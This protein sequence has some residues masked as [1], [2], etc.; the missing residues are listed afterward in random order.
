MS[1]TEKLKL[2][3]KSIEKK[4]AAIDAELTEISES[5][6]A[7]DAAQSITNKLYATFP[8]AGAWL[9]WSMNH[10]VEYLY[11]YGPHGMR[12]NLFAVMTGIK[13]I[14]AAMK[15]RAA[16]SP[17]QGFASQIGVTAARLII[18]ELYKTL[19][20]FGY[21]TKKSRV[22]P[23]DITKA[24]HDALH[25]ESPYE[26]VLIV[27]H[28]IQYMATYGVT[29]WYKDNYG[30]TFPIEPEIEM[31]FGASED[32]M[33]KWDWSQ[34][35]LFE[36]LYRSL[37]NQKKLGFCKG[38]EDAY[39]KIVSAYQNKELRKYLQT[40]YPILG[41][42]PTSTYGKRGFPSFEEISEFVRK[43]EEK[44]KAKEKEKK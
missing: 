11:T 27:T 24:V 37:C 8:K 31:E 9:T 32:E 36:I 20:H 5:E 30:I 41:V 40:N 14:I 33:F 25:T 16:N 7:L 29:K 17:I 12:R 4:M 19:L 18:E 15:R 35:H 44:K 2:E 42:E 23:A 22:M 43:K 28:V 39:S 6:E 21:M 38:V 10:V 3:L 26:I 1:K 13:S 34:D